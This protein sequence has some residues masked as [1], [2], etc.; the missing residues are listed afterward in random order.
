MTGFLDGGVIEEGGGYQSQRSL[1]LRA[2]ATAYLSRTPASTSNQT[3]WTWSAWVKR[4]VLSQQQTLFAAANSGDPFL[5]LVYDSSV[6]SFDFIYYV[7]GV[8]GRKTTT[9]AYRDP[10]S[11]YHVL[12]NWDTTNATASDRMRIYVNGI[13]VTSFSASTD[14][15][16]NTTGT[17][18][19]SSYGHSIGRLFSTTNLFDGYMAE[20]NF[21]DGQALTPSSFGQTDPTTG[22]WTAKKYSGSYG[23]NGFYLDFDD[24]T[25]PTTLC[26]DRSGNANNWTPNNISTTAGATYDS[27][28]DVPLGGG[29]AERGNYAVLSPLNPARSTLSNGNLTASGTTDLPTI[30][31]DS[32]NWYFEIGGVS[33]NWTPPAAFPAAAGDYNFGQ[34]PLTNSITGGHKLLHTGNLPT[35]TGAARE[36]KKHFDVR[37]RTGTG[38][39]ASVADLLFQPD[40]AWIKARSSVR[41]HG[42]FDAVRGINKALIS[43][44]PGEEQTLTNSLTA[45]NSNGYTVGSSAGDVVVVNLVADPAY[46]DWIW[47]AG[48]AAVTNTAGSIS[49]QVSANVAAGFSIVTWNGNSTNATVGHGLGAVPGLVIVKSRSSVTNWVVWHKAGTGLQYMNLN[50]TGGWASASNVW[51]S[52]VPSSS[53]ISLGADAGVNSTGSTYV[54]Y[55]FAEIPGYSKIGSYTG[56]GSADG[57]MVWCGFRPRYVMVKRIDT[58]GHWQLH[59]TARDTYNVGAYD[60]YPSAPDAEYSGVSNFALDYTTSGFKPR[61]ANASSNASGGTYIFYAIS[62]AN[63]KYALAR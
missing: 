2:G 51:N 6:N 14:P 8:V 39:T 10:S 12:V 44:S 35:P 58:T 52:T 49:S 33:K 45:F 54:A 7:A 22:Q 62:E 4:G 48:G 27:M 18:N 41:D 29:G 20:V 38:A 61:S 5:Q 17:V 32:G 26:Y 31:P 36:P 53:L 42:L 55:C 30:L 46:V 3:T 57:P 56:N 1:R 37:L 19:S 43:N 13:R 34:R 24:P 11:W 25:S 15:S 63:F 23:T 50:G 40:F 59:D 16:Q 47:K 28:L 21:I 60:L 9:A